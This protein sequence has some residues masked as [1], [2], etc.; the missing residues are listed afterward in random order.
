MFGVSTAY[1]AVG[2][3]YLRVQVAEHYFANDFPNYEPI[4]LDTEQNRLN[5]ALTVLPV[6]NVS[7]IFVICSIYFLI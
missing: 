3:R 5:V 7:P 4:V 2:W 1:F 6:F